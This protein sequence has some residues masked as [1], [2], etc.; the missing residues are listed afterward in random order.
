MEIE[1]ISWHAYDP[2]DQRH[3]LVSLPRVRWLERDPDYKPPR[4]DEPP[5]RI[6]RRKDAKISP[7]KVRGFRPQ[8]RNDELSPA[9]KEA[10]T[11]H[12]SGMKLAEIGEK[13][14]RSANAAG[15]LLI[16]AR[17]KLGVEL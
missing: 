4:S 7:S 10:W 16:Q 5:P 8:A 15:K 11:L 13:M 12:L 9:Q 2:K 3:V 14:G 6:D 1:R 17:E